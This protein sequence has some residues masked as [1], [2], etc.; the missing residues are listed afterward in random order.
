MDRP[1]ADIMRLS[2]CLCETIIVSGAAAGCEVLLGWWG[3]PV[4]KPKPA[5]LPPPPPPPPP[6]PKQEAEAA[7][8]DG[9]GVG[10][11]GP[12]APG[13]GREGAPGV[14]CVESVEM[15]YEGAAYG[16]GA[17]GEE[18]GDGAA[19]GHAAEGEEEEDDRDAREEEAAKRRA[20]AAEAEEEED[21]ERSGEGDGHGDSDGGSDDERRRSGAEEE[22][23]DGDLGFGGGEDQGDHG[24]DHLGVASVAGVTGVGPDAGQGH[25]ASSGHMVHDM[26]EDDDEDRGEGEQ[27]GGW[28]RRFRNVFI[29]KGSHLLALNVESRCV[30]GFEGARQG[31]VSLIWH[32]GCFARSSPCQH[33]Q[34]NTKG[35][36]PAR[37]LH[38]MAHVQI[39]LC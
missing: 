10:A 30:V 16:E 7:R 34:M 2:L 13:K 1:P 8:H 17:E 32:Q 27:C 23:D 19:E 38:C 22:E 21:Q 3:P 12:S 6:R 33:R 31:C 9:A 37:A 26:E 18:G 36:Q 14:G 29:R 11:G 15:D 35:S 39:T 28:G 5:L 25:G 4:P 24:V 20:E